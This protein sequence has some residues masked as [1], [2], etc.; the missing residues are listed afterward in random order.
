MMKYVK[1]FQTYCPVLSVIMLHTIY[2]YR[3][4]T[5]N[6]QDYVTEYSTT[7]ITEGKLCKPLND[8]FFSLIQHI[9]I[10][11]F[12]SSTRTQKLLKINQ[13]VDMQENY[14]FLQDA[15]VPRSTELIFARILNQV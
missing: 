9:Y 11:F 3:E 13:A 6:C 5:L 15:S 2:I 10:H 4:I 8:W 14:P 7:E 1:Q 12:L